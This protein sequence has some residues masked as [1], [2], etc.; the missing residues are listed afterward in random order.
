MFKPKKIVILGHFGVGKTS[1]L[2]RYVDD[3]FSEDYIVTLGVQV[4]KKSI[5][6]DE[7][8]YDLIIWDL[9]GS[10]N[11][12]NARSSYLLGTHGFLYVFDVSRPETYANL[13][14][15]VIYLQENFNTIPYQIIGNKADLIED[16]SLSDFF[17]KERF[18]DVI[19]TSAKDDKNVALVFS[20]ITKAMR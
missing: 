13:K 20:E 14:N 15:E 11:I 17:K 6:L 5:T 2:R 1:L 8:T 16:S 10:T 18:K 12:S 19:F 4:K 9:E 7:E 3:A